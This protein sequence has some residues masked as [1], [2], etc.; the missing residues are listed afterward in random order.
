MPLRT[1]IIPPPSDK[2]DGS[3][4][5]ILNS[6]ELQEQL[7]KLKI[8]VDNLK[9][10]SKLEPTPRPETKECQHRKGCDSQGSH[11]NEII[12]TP[13][14]PS[15]KKLGTKTATPEK[16]SNPKGSA[17][18]KI[19]QTQPKDPKAPFKAP[20]R[21]PPS[22]F[23][24]PHQMSS[25]DTST[26]R[27]R[28]NAF[29]SGIEQPPQ[30]P[31]CGQ[32]CPHCCEIRS[33]SVAQSQ[34]ESLYSVPFSSNLYSQFETPF[35]SIT[36]PQDSS[37]GRYTQ[38]YEVQSQPHFP[39]QPRSA[40]LTPPPHHPHSQFGPPF[41]L[42]TQPTSYPQSSFVYAPINQLISSPSLPPRVPSLSPPI[43]PYRKPNS[44]E[45]SVSLPPCTNSCVEFF[46]S[47]TDRVM[48][49]P[50]ELL[51]SQY[52]H[53]RSGWRKSCTRARGRCDEGC[54]RYD[55]VDSYYG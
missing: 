12:D 23:V 20:A 34:P 32:S 48:L 10:Q 1:S 52:P 44:I 21:V 31:P 3:T 19:S 40:Y 2:P 33:Q 28:I 11:R 46:D 55:A 39:R 17:A 35:P 24:P 51:R 45:F 5:T 54:G 29:L 18:T 9:S 16:T 50:R 49:E 26:G 4:K 30:S 8:E 41:P 43:P 15:Q 53:A 22:C 42:F 37:H 38:F 25:E 6:T 14:R 13:E 47:K 36:H 27:D 7:R